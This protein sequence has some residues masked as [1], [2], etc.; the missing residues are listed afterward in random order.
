MLMPHEWEL[1]KGLERLP[2]GVGIGSKPKGDIDS[3]I[4]WKRKIKWKADLD[5]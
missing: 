1:G 2:E 3:S 4:L 5:S